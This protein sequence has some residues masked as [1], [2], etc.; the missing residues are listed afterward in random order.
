MKFCLA[1]FGVFSITFFC[2]FVGNS[3]QLPYNHVYNF[4][5]GGG[6]GAGAGN[7]YPN[8]DISP[9]RRSFFSSPNTFNARDQNPFKKFKIPAPTTRQ[10]SPATGG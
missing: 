2:G 4:Y 10:P 7:G 5:S 6:G 3:A 9:Q 1:V 8:S